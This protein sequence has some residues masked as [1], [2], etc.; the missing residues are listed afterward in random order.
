MGLEWATISTYAGYFLSQYWPYLAFVAAFVI[1]DGL[2]SVALGGESRGVGEVGSARGAVASVRGG[3]T[4][5]VGTAARDYLRWDRKESGE[6]DAFRNER[7]K[8]L[9]L[10]FDEKAATLYGD[11]A[12]DKHRSTMRS[13]R[14]AE[15]K[16][17]KL[18]RG[19]MWRRG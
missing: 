15:R 7:K 8:A 2:G 9:E 1:L 5:G 13:E 18:Y 6:Y 10:G 16:S 3:R 19:R 4:G 12:V 11:I 14:V 17:R